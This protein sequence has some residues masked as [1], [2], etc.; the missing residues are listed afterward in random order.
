VELKLNH[1]A[2]NERKKEDK[3]DGEKPIRGW[4]IPYK[5]STIYADRNWFFKRKMGTSQGYMLAPQKKNH[6]K[7]HPDFGST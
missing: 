1:R 3:V 2:K 6:F 7:N 4:A 5:S